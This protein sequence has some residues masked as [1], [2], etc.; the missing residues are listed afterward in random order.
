MNEY[1]LMNLYFNFIFKD[2][3]KSFRDVYA[4]YEQLGEFKNWLT[5][6]EY[7]ISIC[8]IKF[9]K[10]NVSY[11]LEVKTLKPMIW[12]LKQVMHMIFINISAKEKEKYQVILLS[13][14]DQQ[15]LE[16]F[17]NSYNHD[18]MRVFC[19]KKGIERRYLFIWTFSLCF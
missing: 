15:F 18:L 7:K 14:I 16:N 13:G 10:M 4:S 8:D 12:L 19:I 1:D 6:Q 3:N 11:F 9:K 5:K 2:G 17:D